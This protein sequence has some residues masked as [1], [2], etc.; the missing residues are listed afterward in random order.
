M[1]KE[2]PLLL[3]KR[4]L[5]RASFSC[6]SCVIHYPQVTDEKI[7]ELNEERYR[8]IRAAAAVRQTLTNASHRLDSVCANIPS[9]LDVTN[10]GYHRACYDRFINVKKLQSKPQRVM[11]T[12]KLLST[13]QNTTKRKSVRQPKTTTAGCLILPQNQCIFCKKNRLSKCGSEELL[14]KC[15]TKNAD[16]SIREAA[17]AK[18][19]FELLAKIGPWD[20]R[21]L[22]ARYHESCRKKYLRKDDRTHHCNVKNQTAAS[23]STVSAQRAANDAAF[24]QLCEHITQNII[25]RGAVERM[26]MLREKYLQHLQ[27]H[28]PEFYNPNYKTGKLK[29]RL[30]AHFGDKMNFWQPNYKS[31]LVYSAHIQTGEAVEAAFEAATSESRILEEAAAILRR[32]IQ[33]AHHNAK[34]LPWPPSADSL[35]GESVSIPQ[36]LTEFLSLV[37]TGKSFDHA[38]EKSVRLSKS[39]A[40]DICAATTRGR[41]K[42][43]KHLLLSMTLRTLTG[44]AD[45][46]TLMNRYGHCQSYS[47]TLELETAIANQVQ[48]NES[49]VPSNISTTSNKMAHMCWD[50][51]DINEETPSGAGTTHSTHGI[52]IQEILPEVSEMSETEPERGVERSKNAALS[53]NLNSFPNVEVNGKWNHL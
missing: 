22:E 16:D 31:D 48:Q 12:K 50:N 9:A 27:E 17:A 13:M 11:E 33:F 5:S 24:Q 8:K 4:K 23:S 6:R 30:I 36:S 14:A 10:D 25:H 51:F 18:K 43:P 20:L 47:S 34:D 49:I 1:A 35:A 28:S 2:K 39:F 21:S 37:V 32:N 42:M 41:W 52:V 40:E 44:R 38:T 45:I 53:T 46:V 26:T 15:L 3:K 19:D 29:A 7:V